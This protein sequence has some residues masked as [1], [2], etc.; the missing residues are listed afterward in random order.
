MKTCFL[1]AILFAVAM[2]VC[3]AGTRTWTDRTGKH[4]TEAS[5]IHID[6]DG[7]VHLVD[8]DGKR[9]AV[10]IDR[11][12]EAD[13][14]YLRSLDRQ[15]P[16]HQ[17]PPATAAPTVASRQSDHPG[18]RLGQLSPAARAILADFQ[19]SEP[20][21][22]EAF[23]SPTV[24][25][26]LVPSRLNLTA[27]LWTLQSLLG[28]K[29]DLR[30]HETAWH[31]EA[32]TR[33]RLRFGIT[34]RRVVVATDEGSQEHHVFLGV[35]ISRGYEEV[36]LP[37]IGPGMSI[38]YE[39]VSAL[40]GVSRP[41]RKTLGVLLTD[42][43]VLGCQITAGRI[44]E[45]NW[46]IVEE[47]RKMYSVVSV[48]PA[49]PITEKY[50]VLLAVQP[51]SLGPTEMSHFVAAVRSGQPT[52]I[53]EDP[54]PGFAATVPA[55]SAPRR[56]GIPTLM[57]TMRQPPKPKG[58]I[59]QLWQCLGVDFPADQIIWQ[60]YNPYLML[61]DLPVE[62]VFIDKECGA[63]EPFAMSE[64]ITDQLESMLFPFPGSILALPTS[65]RTFRPLV[66]TGRKTGT[67]SYGE[68][69]TQGMFGATRLNPKR[70]LVSTETSYVLAAYITG[71]TES[72]QSPISVVLVA[73]I[74]MLD[75]QLFLIQQRKADATVP[76]EFHF[77]NN[78]FVRNIIHVLCGD[79]GLAKLPPHGLKP[80]AFADLDEELRQARAAVT[81]K[82]DQLDKELEEKQQESQQALNDRME[83]LRE[84]LRN[85]EIDQQELVRRMTILMKV[86][87]Q[88]M[89][90]ELERL[91]RMQERELGLPKAK[92]VALEQQQYRESNRVWEAQF[93]Q[94]EQKRAAMGGNA[95]GEDSQVPASSENMQGKRLFSVIDP[96]TA[97]HVQIVNFGGSLDARQQLDLNVID[98]RWVFRSQGI[99]VADVSP[100]VMRLLSDLAGA[101]AVDIA[102][103]DV[104]DL[105]R[106]GVV[107]PECRVT[108]EEPIESGTRV[109]VK[110]RDGK[111]LLAAIVGNEVP[112]RP[113]L[114]Y[115]RRVGQDA[116]CMVSI[117]LENIST[118]FADW[119]S[120]NLLQFDPEDLRQIDAHDY[121]VDEKR[122][123]MNHR[124]KLALVYHGSLGEPEWELLECK[125]FEKGLWI[126]A[127][128][129]DD[130]K[131][132]TEHLGRLLA[133][134][135][136]LTI[137]GVRPKPAWFADDLRA[138]K[139]DFR[140]QEAASS[141]MSR[142]FYLAEI[143]GEV[144][145]LAREGELRCLMKDGVEYVLRFGS[146][147]VEFED[148][149][150]MTPTF[151]KNSPLGGPEAARFLFVTTEFNPE[152]IPKPDDDSK[153]PQDA[154]RAKIA[155]GTKRSQSLNARLA[156][157]YYV[158]SNEVYQDIHLS[159][160]L[161]LS[162]VD[163]ADQPDVQTDRDADADTDEEPEKP[164]NMLQAFE[165]FLREGPD[166]EK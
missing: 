165:E 113:G 129:A 121:W 67:E 93:T 98:G 150:A 133:S 27:T 131:L 8:N 128:V 80:L 122:G 110:D 105:E 141:L 39:L 95:A 157:W 66:S 5:L 43:D 112:Q 158:I 62:L 84:R 136:N 166:R 89:K 65:R 108:V 63:E 44:A 142:G 33:A 163:S 23:I 103:T 79:S 28:E 143:E 144:E 3:E 117:P 148:T 34:P 2:G 58:D 68:M 4:T 11:L 7:T 100:R 152:G 155:A 132:D 86:S 88:Q 107:D 91:E 1:V 97:A 40:V 124:G 92:L 37:W 130:A 127:K 119:A 54:F 137:V 149:R 60:A 146:Q 6:D 90:A 153:Q 72:G 106:F 104:A 26:S 71:D 57:M 138:G 101:V 46:P 114:H 70:R 120:D 126:P 18:E 52:A 24:P 83:Q 61:A 162:N 15:E 151:K 42:A 53:F 111:T 156:D 74:D 32:A 19:P 12:S 94:L 102:S 35:A 154:Y 139:S 73:D 123:T 21:R 25:P 147:T 81:L 77:D 140:Y 69:V 134:L 161:I 38:E 96:S 78:F 49:N 160:D 64:A 36:V 48:N 13:Q 59:N 164:A 51:S 30:I 109:T 159:R 55:T 87:Q 75:R 14:V 125:T 56:P 115:V 145:L 47:L 31:G 85:E 22:I 10:L 29:V 16:E 17:R 116:V 135:E 50:D 41:K 82:R 99:E 20:V 76:P 9:I 45:S 118:N